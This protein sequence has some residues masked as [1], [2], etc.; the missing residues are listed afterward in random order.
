[1]LSSENSLMAVPHAAPNDALPAPGANLLYQRALDLCAAAAARRAGPIGLAAA[2]AFFIEEL[3]QRLGARLVV[4]DAAPAGALPELGALIWAGGALPEGAAL[5][6][7]RPTSPVYG[8][9]AG[10]LYRA[11]PGWQ[12]R[13]AEL[14]SLPAVRGCLARRPFHLGDTYGFHGLASG[15]WG[16][17][18]SLAGRAGRDDLADR[19]YANLRESFLV[20]GA[21]AGWS[22]LTLTVAQ[23][24]NRL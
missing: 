11:W 6:A 15:A 22:I 1:M 10:R 12:H 14:P 4:V 17:A 24:R 3:R 8:L 21:A 20:R 16:Y 5:R 23:W 7:L 18:G 13:S 19:C 2:S 9:A